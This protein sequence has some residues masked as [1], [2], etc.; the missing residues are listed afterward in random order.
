MKVYT[1]ISI[2][3][4]WTTQIQSP[5]HLYYLLVLREFSFLFDEGFLLNDAA[6][7]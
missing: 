5:I 1:S 7:E 4:H 2:D 6:L 3:S